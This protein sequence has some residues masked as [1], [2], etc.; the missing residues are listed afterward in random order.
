MKHLKYFENNTIQQPFFLRGDRLYISTEKAKEITPFDKN[1]DK[2]KRKWSDYTYNQNIEF[3]KNTRKEWI[4]SNDNKFFPYISSQANTNFSVRYNGS[5]G[6][7]IIIK[8]GNEQNNNF[9]KFEYTIG[10]NSGDF[11]M[12]GKNMIRATREC[13]LNLMIKVYPI[14]K[15]LKNFYKELKEGKKSFLEIIKDAIINDLSLIK[16]GVPRELESDNELGIYVSM[17]KYNL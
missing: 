11:S 14:I 7:S 13:N 16:Y 3:F 4:G 1:S 12:H 17:N 15:Y 8:R 5:Y 6:M 10:G 9:G 2:T